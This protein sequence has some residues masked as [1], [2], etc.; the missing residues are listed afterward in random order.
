[1]DR[2]STALADALFEELEQLRGEMPNYKKAN[3]VSNVARQIISVARLELDYQRERRYSA[4]QRSQDISLEPMQIGSNALRLISRP[5][6]IASRFV[7]KCPLARSAPP[8][9]TS[10][11]PRGLGTT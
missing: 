5:R 2:T 10:H 6:S 11:P 8:R 4:N 3:A 7:S 9:R 1:M